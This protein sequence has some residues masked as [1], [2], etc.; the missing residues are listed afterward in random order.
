MVRKTGRDG[1]L[2]ISNGCS[3]SRAADCIEAVRQSAAYG[4]LGEDDGRAVEKI[5]SDMD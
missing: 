5:A 1:A 4:D 3:R 2:H